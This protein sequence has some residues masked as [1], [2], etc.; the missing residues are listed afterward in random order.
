M[1]LV[2]SRLDQPDI[3]A[4]LAASRRSG[5]IVQVDWNKDDPRNKEIYSLFHALWTKAVGGTDYDKK[6]WK[7]LAAFLYDLGVE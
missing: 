6:Q 2:F 4:A 1:S 3:D 5:N 7:V